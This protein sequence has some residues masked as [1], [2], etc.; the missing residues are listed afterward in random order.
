MKN[1]KYIALITI[2]LFSNVTFGMQ[3]LKEKQ[4]HVAQEALMAE[5]QRQAKEIQQK[6][7]QYRL[8]MLTS[9]YTDLR[10]QFELAKHASQTELSYMLPLLLGAAKDLIKRISEKE[11][12]IEPLDLEG[13]EDQ[14]KTLRKDVTE[15]C[16]TI[17]TRQVER[18]HEKKTEHMEQRLEKA[19]A[20]LEPLLK[21]KEE[22]AQAALMA[23]EQRQAKE[24]QQVEAQERLEEYASACRGL[25]KQFSL[26]Q[27]NPQHD[28]SISDLKLLL[29]AAENL[30]TRINSDF[31]REKIKQLG[32]EDQYDTLKKDATQ[33]Y[34]TIDAYVFAL[35]W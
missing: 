3:A 33:L 35:Q 7:A 12:S 4:Q 1:A 8:I 26:A 21:I 32:L 18:L 17:E 16:D 11:K 2:T 20:G 34:N 13:L 24:M 29:G 14:Y 5:E 25:L 30:N 23:E 19:K 10:S 27:R 28:I 9:E 6:Q 22:E 31:D 15:L